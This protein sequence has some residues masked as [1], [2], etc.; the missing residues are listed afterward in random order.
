MFHRLLLNIV[1]N[2][3]QAIEE[4]AEKMDYTG[5][6]QLASYQKN[7]KIYLEIADNGCGM[8][9]A[10]RKKILEPFFTTRAKGSGLGMTM[11]LRILQTHNGDLQIQSEEGK[12]T[13]LR[14]ILPIFQKQQKLLVNLV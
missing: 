5:Q 3:I 6:L 11:V 4:K 12:G 8:S 1:Q 14:I 2:A 10:T 9:E 13:L 7:E